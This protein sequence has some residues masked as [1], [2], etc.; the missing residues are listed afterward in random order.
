MIASMVDLENTSARETVHHVSVLS[1]HDAV[2]VP[3]E[4]LGSAESTSKL[5]SGS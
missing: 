4:I 3:T 5:S 2:V 1:V